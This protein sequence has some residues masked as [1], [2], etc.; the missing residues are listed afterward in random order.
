MGCNCNKEDISLR[1]K[2]RQ[3]TKEKISEI[4]RIW[5]E[6]SRKGSATITTGKK[7]LGFK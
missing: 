7:E 4:K 1:Q 5:K 6:S 3:E 2:I